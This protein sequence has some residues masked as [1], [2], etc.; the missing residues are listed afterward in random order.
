LN[1]NLQHLEFYPAPKIVLSESKISLKGAGLLYGNFEI[2]NSAEGELVG[3]ITPM[4]EFISF[5]PNT[6][7]G[8]RIQVEYTVDLTGLNGDIQT[9]AVITSNGGEAVLDFYIT[10]NRGD[11]LERD[12]HV[13]ADLADFAE[14]ARLQPV[15]ARKLFGRH[16]FV[17]WLMNLGYSSMDMYENFANDANKER[18][19]DN[20]LVFNGSK[21]KA[22][23]LPAQRDLTHQIGMWEDVVTGSLKLKKTTWG[24]ADGELEVA[25][26][27]DWLKLSKTKLVG[28]DFDGQNMAEVHYMVLADKVAGRDMGQVLLNGEHKINIWLSPAAAFDA[29]LDK[30]S[31]FFEDTGKLLL[32][33]NTGRD[34]FIEIACEDFVRFDSKRYPVGQ[35][36]EI[37]FSLKYGSFRAST[38]SFKKQLYAET[39]I[40]V[41]VVGESGT[42]FSRRLPL[43]LW[44]N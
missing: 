21:S 31:F 2:Y 44:A 1:K 3:S 28:S 32:T 26:G 10:A 41:V 34:I 23:V 39:S 20:F 25:K 7:S 43:T 19:L 14:Y 18:A 33:N 16:D 12:G 4:V 15:E 9:A 35:R 27:A 40:Q 36:L 5:S 13:M 11:V 24:Y 6:F 22:V 42:G 17:L 38:L 29:R 30:Q 37:E 8:N